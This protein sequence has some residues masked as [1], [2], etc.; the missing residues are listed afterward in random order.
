M[1]LS[2]I[3]DSGDLCLIAYEGELRQG[4]FRPDVDPLEAIIGPDRQGRTILMDLSRTSY[5]DSS[6]VSWLV[7]QHKVSLEA[8]GGFILHSVP[9][10]VMSI[11]KLL[12]LDRLLRFAEDEHS[13]RT[14][15]GGGAR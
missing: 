15:A 9:P 14:L 5:I 4:V 10:S 3:Q 6:G 7:K 12:H 2:L 8:K 13:A 1:A 11:F